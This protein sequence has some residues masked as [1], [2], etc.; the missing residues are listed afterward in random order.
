MNKIVLDDMC[1]NFL[2]ELMNRATL[3]GE[4]VKFYNAIMNS[5]INR[6]ILTNKPKEKTVE[7]EN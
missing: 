7:V 5:I 6:E 1:L 2:I 4:E 3:K